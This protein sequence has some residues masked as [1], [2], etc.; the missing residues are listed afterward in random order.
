MSGLLC[1]VIKYNRQSDIFF[2]R[3]LNDINNGKN[4]R[5]KTFLIEQDNIKNWSGYVK[6]SP[7]LSAAVSILSKIEKV[8][9]KAYIVGGAVRDIVLGNEPHDIDIATNMSIKELEKTFGKVYDIGKSKSF[10]IVVVRQ[11]GYDFEIAQFR[12]DGTYMDGRRPESVS[13]TGKFEDDAARRDFTINSMGIDSK[14]NIIDYFDGKKAIKNKTIKTVGNPYKRFSEDYLRMLRGVR[15]AA[16]LGFDIDPETKDA[17]K[18]NKE[19]LLSISAER[20]RDELI[21]MASQTGDKFADAIRIMDEVGILGIILPELIKQKDFPEHPE[22]HP[23]AYDK[24]RGGTVLDHTV[25]ALRKNQIADPLVNLSILMHDIGKPISY[26]FSTEKGRGTFFGHAEKSKDLIDIIAKRLKL[27]NKQKNAIMFATVNHMKMHKALDMKP[28]KIVKLMQDEN[29]EVLK[30]VSYCDDSCRLHL[31][32]K[33]RFEK[34]IKGMEKIKDKWGE[35]TSNNTLKIVNGKQVME[36]TGLKPGKK[37]GEIIQKVTSW[38][39]D[40]GLKDP[41]EKLIMKAYR[42]IENAL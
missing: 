28:S 24:G 30:V 23:E 29:W 35:K 36:I 41:M 13:I 2:I 19:K 39:V 5:F 1:R 4:M 12:K 18:T 16:K 26:K 25:A 9:K 42:E 10:G 20:I 7:M 31:F 3:N 38:I 27:T 8:G 15:F 21:K 37:V 33:N 22:F 40:D 6:S 32:D 14:G 11:G 17:I 34:V